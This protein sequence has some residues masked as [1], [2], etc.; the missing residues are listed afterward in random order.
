MTVLAPATSSATSK[1][2]DLVGQITTSTMINNVTNSKGKVCGSTTDDYAQKWLE[3]FRRQQY[4]IHEYHPEAVKSLESAMSSPDGAYAVTYEQVDTGGGAKSPYLAKVYWTEID[5]ASFET[6]FTE[7]SDGGPKKAMVIRAKPGLSKKIHSATIGSPSMVAGGDAC[8]PEFLTGYTAQTDVDAIW[9][10]AQGGSHKLLFST[11]DVIY[12]AGYSGMSVPS[13]DLAHD[14]QPTSSHYDD[15]MDKITTNTLVN[16]INNYHGKTCGSPTS[17]YASSWLSAAQSG[18]MYHEAGYYSDYVQSFNK[19]MASGAYAIGYSQKN[20]HDNTSNPY[21]IVVFWAENKADFSARFMGEY[22]NREIR[23]WQNP[24][25]TS[26]LRR[27]TIGSPTLIFDKGNCNI[28]LM[29]KDSFESPAFT[30]SKNFKLF[31]STFDVKYPAGYRGA[32]VPGNST[33]LDYLALGDSFSS[34][35]GDTEK[36][37]STDQKYYRQF[38]D[39]NENKSRNTPK[40]KCHV[41]TR[42]YPY[43]L[44]QQMGLSQ[45]GTK[46]WDTVACSGAVIYDMNGDN[47]SG[48]EGQDSPLGR[49]NGY[50]DKEALKGMA[51][52]EIIPGRVKQ[53][54]FVKKYQP[55]VITLTAGGNDVDFGGKL[56]ACVGFFSPGDCTWAKTEWRSK[57]KNELKDQFDKLRL[58]Y[59]ELKVASKGRARIYVLGYPQFVN[60]APDAQCSNTFN[61]NPREREMIT[62]SITY[63]NNVIRQAARAAGVKYIDIEN[64]FGNHWLCGDKDSHVTAITHIFG[65]NGNERQESFHPNAKGHADIARKFREE[66]GGVSPMDY[67]ICPGGA[68]SCPDSSA[69]KDKIPAPPYFDV[70]NE[71]EDIKFTYYQLTNG[72]ATKVEEKWIE[73]K[74]SRRPYK[75]HKKVY[76]KIYSDPRDLGEIETDENGEIDGRVALPEDLPAGYHTLVVSGESPSGEKTELYQTILIKGANPEDIDENSILDKNQPCGAFLPVANEDKDFD[77][78]DDACDPEI[79]DPILYSARNGNSQLGEDEDRIYL[80]RNTRAS[81]L[82]GITNDYIDKSKNQNNTDALVG[83]TLSEETR[84]LAFEKLVIMKEDDKEND[85]PKGM[86]IV[87]T[88]DINEKCY[89]LKPEDYLS[90]SLKPGSNDY[91]PRG[92]IKLNTLPKGVSCE[93]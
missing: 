92:L 17:D 42:S 29:F 27:A 22:P 60:G 56:A 67:E 30:E 34:G 32:K 13:V 58:L 62:N 88:K 18:D 85:I 70:A 46:Q 64:A 51:L 15:L 36:N 53:I 35:E 61:L 78:I 65:A 39:V 8:I 38:T 9:F 79:T 72:A 5:K 28:E 47:S 73:I 25:A 83:Y 50:S 1:Y 82:T 11:F 87:V 45:S 63:Y 71:Q 2:D 86:P 6:V 10:K 68:T 16:Y 33:K 19:A 31:K 7:I 52:N 57:L 24:G 41:S 49:L 12:P 59:D 84:G 93:E 40:E 89:A 91:T 43:K 48:Y 37:P 20:N 23:I 14:W 81:K 4:N 21:F 76:V 66:L 90:P 3:S 26:V 75:P 74:T 55:K 44:A 80:F 54:E 69:T 77:G